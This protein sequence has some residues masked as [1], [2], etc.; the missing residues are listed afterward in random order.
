MFLALKQVG[1]NGTHTTY[2]KD[3]SLESAGAQRGKK[4]GSIDE[5]FNTSRR[6]R[7]RNFFIGSIL[8]FVNA[9]FLWY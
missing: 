3:S 2:L 8:G 7:F 1:A 6:I 5:Q 4:E 9:I